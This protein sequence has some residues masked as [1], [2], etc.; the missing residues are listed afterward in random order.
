MTRAEEAL[1]RVRV[2]EKIRELRQARQLTARTI[3]DG[4]GCSESHIY[5]IESGRSRVSDGDR[6][7]I[8]ALLDV[9]L[10]DLAS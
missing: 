1:N 3:A 8:A 10:E 5:N 2:G 7:A 4:I 6:A 9:T